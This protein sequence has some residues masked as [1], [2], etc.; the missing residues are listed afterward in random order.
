MHL[1]KQK[2]L[3]AAPTQ[4]SVGQNVSETHRRSSQATETV[5]QGKKKNFYH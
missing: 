2:A 5:S 3:S 1:D 4:L